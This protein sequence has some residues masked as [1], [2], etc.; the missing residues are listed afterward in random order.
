MFLP[1]W[2]YSSRK[3]YKRTVTQLPFK[4]ESF[5]LTPC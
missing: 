5:D 3:R 1:S 2:N 4:S